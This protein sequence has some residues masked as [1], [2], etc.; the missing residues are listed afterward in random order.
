[1]TVEQKRIE[2]RQKR[3]LRAAI[4]LNVLSSLM[5]KNYHSIAESIDLMNTCLQ[6]TDKKGEEL[7]ETVEKRMVDYGIREESKEQSEDMEMME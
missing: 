5:D 4:I 1:M 6:F 3:Q 7:N 2:Y